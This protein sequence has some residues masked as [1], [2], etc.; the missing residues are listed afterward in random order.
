[1]KAEI[2]V[3][4]ECRVSWRRVTGLHALLS[5]QKYRLVFQRRTREIGGKQIHLYHSAFEFSILIGHEVFR[6]L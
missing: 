4:S 5:V 3:M 6:F 2:V 1:M